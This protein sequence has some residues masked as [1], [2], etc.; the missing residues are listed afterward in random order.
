M[1]DGL[2]EGNLGAR[3]GVTRQELGAKGFWECFVADPEFRAPGGVS[4]R[5][6]GEPVA[7]TLERIAGRD[8]SHTVL[9]ITYQGSICQGFAV[10]R[11][12]IPLPGSS[13]AVAN[14]GSTCFASASKGRSSDAVGRPRTR[15]RRNDGTGA[16]TALSKRAPC[17][18]VQ[19]ARDAG[20]R[21]MS[22]SCMSATWP[23]MMSLR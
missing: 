9:A 22:R 13:N 21:Q 15:D 1:E 11:D 10:L 18:P 16:C 8:A 20:L 23:S 7:A 12:E 17:G 2:I 19:S 14:G 4:A 3:E 5:E 6:R